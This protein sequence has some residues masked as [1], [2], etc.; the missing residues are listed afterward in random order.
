MVAVIFPGQGSQVPG[1]GQELCASFPAASVVFDRVSGAT[2]IDVRALCFESDAEELRETQNAQLA[3]FTCGL[4]AWEALRSSVAVVPDAF[5]GHSIGE[6]A[7]LVAAGALSLAEGAKLV[8]RRGELMASAG[9]DRPGTM[10]AV[11]GL[12]SGP[13]TN[14]C[15]GAS[16]A[17][18]V[19]VVAND[20][21]PGQVVISGDIEAVKR[22]SEDA[23]TAGAKRVLP[24]NVSGAF[25]S[26]LMR[27][28]AAQ[29]GIALAAAQWDAQTSPV[30]SNVTAEAIDDSSLWAYL[31]EQQ[32]FSSVR[33]RESML[34]MIDG[35]F[36]TF[37]ECGSGEVLC[38]LLKRISK[39]VSGM[40]VQDSASLAVTVGKL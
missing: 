40:S 15:E 38:G 25:H 35:G 24:L 11:L 29:M 33:W 31:L 16:D 22:A 17:K 3:L 5:A 2:G 23:I 9:R 26:P 28:S 39:D 8:V 19:V 27:E 34:G 37:I 1:M 4:A 10:A 12:D 18:S 32:L 7:A 14:V 20:N 13:L 36:D 6:Y 30:V 21:C